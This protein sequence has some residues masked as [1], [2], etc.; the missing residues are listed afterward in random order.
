M[1]PT[2]AEDFGAQGLRPVLEFADEVRTADNPYLKL[3]GIV[4]N[5]RAT[6]VGLHQTFERRLREHYGRD[7]FAAVIPRLMGYPEAIGHMQPI[8][9]HD[10]KSNAAEAMRTLAAELIER[11]GGNPR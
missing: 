9:W 2:E 7:V 10:P 1:V 3:A 6:R 4:V 8:T 11:T 5:K